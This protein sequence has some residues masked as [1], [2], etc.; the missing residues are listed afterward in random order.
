MFKIG[1]E[2]FAVLTQKHYN[3]TNVGIRK[4]YV[5]DVL[6][7]VENG[8]LTRKYLYEEYAKQ[9]QI[10]DSSEI[11]TE[12]V[13]SAIKEANENIDDIVKECKNVIMIGKKNGVK[14]K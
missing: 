3:K 6:Q 1:Q 13:D 4:A 8:I 11:Q 5:L 10:K 9:E 14:V 7:N 12:L 2:V